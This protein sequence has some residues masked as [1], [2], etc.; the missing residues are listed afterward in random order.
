[1]ESARGHYKINVRN[2]SDHIADLDGGRRMV[3]VRIVGR[4]DFYSYSLARVTKVRSAYTSHVTR[5]SDKDT[6]TWIAV[7]NA[8]RRVMKEASQG[9][10]FCL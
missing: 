7:F 2:T 8:S 3:C 10:T 5:P 6:R 9:E 4:T 1:M